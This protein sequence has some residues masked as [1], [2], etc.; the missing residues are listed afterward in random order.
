MSA[1]V[2]RNTDHPDVLETLA[3]RDPLTL[4][5]D[6]FVRKI[7]VASNCKQVVEA[8]KTGTSASYGAIVHEIVERS[9]SFSSCRISHEF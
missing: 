4:S 7:G 6:I 2:F 1:V 8:T 9:K 3:I 5:D